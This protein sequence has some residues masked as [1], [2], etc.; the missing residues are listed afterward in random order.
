MHCKTFHHQ[1]IICSNF[2]LSNFTWPFTH[3]VEAKKRQA[4]YCQPIT[5][6]GLE[7]YGGLDPLNNF[8][9]PNNQQQQLFFTIDLN[10]L[11]DWEFNAGY[12]IG[13]TN[14]TDKSMPIP[15]G[16]RPAFS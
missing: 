13:F 2:T 3:L 1:E 7:Y 14:V 6:P 4:E 10:F 11:T 5:S 16:I 8:N 9:S 12:G 15:S